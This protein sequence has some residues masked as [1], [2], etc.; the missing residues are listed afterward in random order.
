M[1][2][3]EGGERECTLL[4][5]D[6]LLLLFAVAAAIFSAASERSVVGTAAQTPTAPRAVPPLP[7]PTRTAHV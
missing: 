3:K 2:S 4:H 6:L 1:G 7:S 5:L